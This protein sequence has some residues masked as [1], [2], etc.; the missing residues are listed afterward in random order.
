M[1]AILAILKFKSADFDLSLVK[2]ISINIY[3]IKIYIYLL[4]Y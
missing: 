1:L 3:N 4:Y 2:N